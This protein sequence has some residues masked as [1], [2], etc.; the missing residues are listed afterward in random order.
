MLERGCLSGHEPTYIR[1]HALPFLYN[2]SHWRTW[3]C[4]CLRLYGHWFF[5]ITWQYLIYYTK[6]LDIFY[7]L[8]YLTLDTSSVKLNITAAVVI[9]RFVTMVV[10]LYSHHNGHS[11]LSEVLQSQTWTVSNTILLQLWLFCYTY[12]M[13]SF[14]LCL[15]YC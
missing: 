5:N 8:K 4:I 15:R 11:Q 7:C 1:E 9:W 3:A 6:I 14:T 12:V 13:L 2:H 10:S